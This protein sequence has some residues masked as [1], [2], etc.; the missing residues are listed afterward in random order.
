MYVGG[1]RRVRVRR[2]P[3]KKSLLVGAL[4]LLAVVLVASGTAVG[5]TLSEQITAAAQPA[6]VVLLPGDG[7]SGVGPTTPAAVIVEHGRID[8]VELIGEKGARVPGSLSADGARWLPNVPLEFDTTY[9]WSG[10]AVGVD[11]ERLPIA[12]SFATVEPK[13]LVKAKVNVADGATY[14]VA[15]PIA[16]DFSTPVADRAAAER[17]LSVRTSTPVNGAWAWLS[18][19]SVHWRP[20]AYFPAN[21]QVTVSAELYGLDLGN[22]SYGRNDVTSTFA[23]GRQ[24]ILRGDTQAHRL[25]AFADGVQ[26]ADYKASFGL[27]SDPRRVTRSGVH[28]AMTRHST[29]LMNSQTFGYTDLPVNWAVRISNNG[30]FTHAAPWSV[31]AQGRRNVSHG[32]INLST[33]DAKAVYDAVITGDP[34]EISGSSR[35]LTTRDGLYYDWAIP[36]DE[37]RTR[38]ALAASS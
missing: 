30:E 37:W 3:P 5:G 12:G 24:F 25:Q 9:T 26:V 27:D 15:M 22:G 18:D 2:T 16:V 14:G 31:G 34:I 4:S 13:K 19:T 1:S 17:A 21:T 23:I 7:R 10:W 35:Q 20:K 33:P 38:S 6:R 29:Y 32:C 8:T 11:G 36:W 28:V